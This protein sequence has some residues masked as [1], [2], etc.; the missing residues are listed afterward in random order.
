MEEKYKLF[1][2]TYKEFDWFIIEYF[3]EESLEV[4]IDFA[5]VEN[6]VLFDVLNDMWYELPDNKF[7][8]IENPKGWN[9][10]LTIIER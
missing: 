2:D 5:K 4:L 10:F 8:I 3:G 7:N 6:P 1:L 9:E